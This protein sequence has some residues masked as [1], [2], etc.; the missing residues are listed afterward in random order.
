MILP[1][2]VLLPGCHNSSSTFV[3]IFLAVLIVEQYLIL[4][5]VNFLVFMESTAS[6]Y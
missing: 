4:A 6:V 2:F 1:P 5:K 3:L